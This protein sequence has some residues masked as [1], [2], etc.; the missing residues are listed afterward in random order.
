MKKWRVQTVKGYTGR[1][2]AWTEGQFPI[3]SVL[4]GD[5]WWRAE[6]YINAE[7]HD[8]DTFRIRGVLLLVEAIKIRSGYSYIWESID[9]KARYPMF[10]TELMKIMQ[11]CGVDEGGYV[12]GTFDVVKRGTSCGIRRIEEK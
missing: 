10:H 1:E 8:P 9:T 2:L 3:G 6:R 11:S 7:S 4:R 5:E 12:D